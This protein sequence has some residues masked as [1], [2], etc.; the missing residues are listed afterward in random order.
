VEACPVQPRKAIAFAEDKRTS[1]PRYAYPLCIRCYCC[2][3]M[4]PHKA[5]NVKTPLPGRVLARLLGK[6]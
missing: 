5:I 4:C 2:Q 3:E 1:P 6:F